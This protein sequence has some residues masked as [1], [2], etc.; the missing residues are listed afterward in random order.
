MNSVKPSKLT[1][2]T[3]KGKTIVINKIG[4]CLKVKKKVEINNNIKKNKK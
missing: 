4:S 2:K 1:T 3:V